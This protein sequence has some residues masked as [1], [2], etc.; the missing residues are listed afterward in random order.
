MKRYSMFFNREIETLPLF[1]LR[2]LQNERLR[3]LVQRVNQHVPFLP[4]TI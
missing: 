3:N 2:E 4:E 1:K